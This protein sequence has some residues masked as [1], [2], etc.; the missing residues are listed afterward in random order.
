MTGITPPDPYPV[1]TFLQRPLHWLWRVPTYTALLAGL[2][3]VAWLAWGS[4]TAGQRESAAAARFMLLLRA[5]APYHSTIATLQRAAS[6][7]VGRAAVSVAHATT[8][9]VSADSAQ[10]LA[11]AAA[12]AV[13][14]AQT[15]QDTIGAQTQQIAALTGTA[16]NLRLTV[17]DY[18]DAQAQMM[19]A[20]RAVRIEADTAE[21][22]VTALESAGR[23]LIRATECRLISWH[24]CIP[25]V[26]IGVSYNQNLVPNQQRGIG[27]AIVWSP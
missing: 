4:L 3:V 27:V 2:A 15:A 1:I 17:R 16:A 18:Q 13:Q 24:P 12:L 9:L 7:H 6:A 19:A 21:A 20:Y 14:Q 8:G 22:R 10:K 11:D 5:T 23:A 25:R 26:H